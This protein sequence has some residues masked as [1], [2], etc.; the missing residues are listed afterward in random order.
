MRFY[1]IRPKLV[2]RAGYRKVFLVQI[3]GRENFVG[4]AILNKERATLNLKRS[5]RDS[6]H[7]LPRSR[8]IATPREQTC[9]R[10]A[11]IPMLRGRSSQTS[12]FTSSA[13]MERIA[14]SNCV[15]LYQI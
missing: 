12:R 4:R 14:F 1:L 6:C 7:H 13:L 3:F 15:S 2:D 8:S 9:D 5:C 11:D 10:D